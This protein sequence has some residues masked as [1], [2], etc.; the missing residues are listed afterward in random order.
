LASVDLS[1]GSVRRVIAGV[2]FDMRE[3]Q[4]HPETNHSF[5][6]LRLPEWNTLVDT[7]RAASAAMSG[8]RI[9]GWDIALSDRGPLL[10]E[11]NFVGHLDI[12]QFADGI[13]VAD[14]V[15]RRFIAR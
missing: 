15:W 2:G 12:F 4:R 9:Q 14:D 7:C 13:G 8:I 6:D 10:Q 5:A 11:V 3:L 1:N